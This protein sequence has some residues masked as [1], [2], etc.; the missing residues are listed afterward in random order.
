MTTKPT[1]KH[2]VARLN[3]LGSDQDPIIFRGQ[4]TTAADLL[5][6]LKVDTLIES[7]RVSYWSDTGGAR[8]KLIKNGTLGGMIRAR[9]RG[10]VNY[11]HSLME[12]QRRCPTCKRKF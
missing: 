12:S 10:Q 5:P 7:F 8:L 6:L 9:E 2:A 3:E 11:T 1:L 4:E